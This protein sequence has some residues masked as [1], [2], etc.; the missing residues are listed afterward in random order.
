MDHKNVVV[1]QGSH[2]RHRRGTGLSAL[3]T[4]SGHKFPPVSSLFN[5][6]HAQCRSPADTGMD[7]VLPTPPHGADHTQKDVGILVG[8]GVHGWSGG[9][10][11]LAD[12]RDP[13][14]RAGHPSFR[15]TD[16]VGTMCGRSSHPSLRPK[17]PVG[18]GP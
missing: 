4:Q 16:E 15:F 10:G 11:A 6:S 3:P 1:L 5:A 17:M 2:D 14:R 18:R 7:E 12:P 9:M 8:E 13:Q